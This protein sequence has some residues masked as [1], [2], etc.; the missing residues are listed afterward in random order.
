MEPLK[1]L[2]GKITEL[3]RGGYLIDTI[4]GYI[5]IGSPPETIKD[6]MLL[7][8]GVPQIFVLTSELFSKE[9]GIS[10]A[11]LE[12][13]I[14]Y[15]FFLKQRKTIIVCTEEQAKRLRKSLKEAIFG[16][17]KLNIKDDFLPLENTYI[18]DIEAEMKFF[19]GNVTLSKMMKFGVFKNGEYRI[20]NNIVIKKL[21]SGDFEIIENNKK[22]RVSGK[23]DYTP[24]YKI[25]QRLKE[26]FVPPL[27]GVTCLGPSHGFDPY[28]NTSGYIIWLNHNGIMIDPPVNSTEWLE[29]SNV[30]PKFIDSIILTHTHADHDAGTFQKI[31]EE[32]RITIYTTKT[33]LESFL[34]KYSALTNLSVSYLRQLFNFYPVK[35]NNPVFI[36]GG[37]FRMFYSLHSI[38]T[39]GFRIEF[40]GKTFVYSSDHNNDPTLHKK[41]YEMGIISKERYKELR[42]FPWDSDVI[43]H[44][45]GIPPLHTPVKFLNSLPEKIQKKI[46]VYHIAKKDFPEKTSLTLAKFGIENTLYFKINRPHFEN[47]YKILD[48]L[49]SM[50]IFNELGVEKTQEFITIVQEEKFK[51]GDKIIEKGKKGYKFFII[52]SGNVS[53]KTK[54]SESKKI[55]GTYD[56]FGEVALI[57]DADRSADVVAETNVVAYSIEKEKFLSFISETKFEKMLLRLART[58]SA[59][60]WE[61]LS[62]SPY[63]RYCTPWQKTWIESMLIP[64]VIKANTRI[65]KEG[66]KLN[67]IYIIRKGNVEVRKKNK[68]IA[69]LKNKDFIGEIDKIYKNQLSSYTF[70]NK[71]EI[72]VF[73]IVKDDIVNFL[74]KNPGLLLKFMYNFK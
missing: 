49:R 10:I 40:Q 44:E 53:V 58:R 47:I 3:P 43:Y 14:Y 34:K 30:N 56:Y 61:L 13:P 31:I 37:K 42:N 2:N 12:F 73:R 15:N 48:V 70:I 60:T 72:S 63:F 24:E 29:K 39:M 52:Y 19:R 32:G 17:D 57:T 25:G 28:E 22:I 66:E 41:L 1:Q 51:K 54:N 23:I 8:K 38:P 69:T 33:I 65:I 67:N 4:A 26:P 68:L 45:A 21:P 62:T 35:I 36:H 16:P 27:F 55:Y 50:D 20:N 71:E 64:D 74:R 5:Q 9:K 6:T 11:E 18:P 59:E 46:V 7:P